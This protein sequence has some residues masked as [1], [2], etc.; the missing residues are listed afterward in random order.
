MEE[1]AGKKV[2]DW[3]Q[4]FTDSVYDLKEAGLTPRQRKYLLRWREKYR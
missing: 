4:L 1:A 2:T 3:P